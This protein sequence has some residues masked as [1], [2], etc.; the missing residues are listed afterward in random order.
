V[1]TPPWKV[2]YCTGIAEIDSQH[3]RFFGI[4]AKLAAADRLEPGVVAPLLAELIDYSS[5]H[6]HEEEGFMRAAGYAGYAAHCREHRRFSRGILELTERFESG[7]PGAAAAILD[8][9]GT[10]LERHILK[11]DRVLRRLPGA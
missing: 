9:V 4:A 6:F 7:E 10:W 11:E 8:F 3:D 2:E 5:F 1:T